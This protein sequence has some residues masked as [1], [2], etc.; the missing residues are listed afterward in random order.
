MN[1]ATIFKYNDMC[2]LNKEAYQIMKWICIGRSYRKV[3]ITVP[4]SPLVDQN[5]ENWQGF[6]Q[7]IKFSIQKELKFT[8]KKFQVEINEIK[9]Q[10]KMILDMV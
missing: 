4:D 6:V 5:D 7:T 2:A 1:K 9:E 10:N 8:N 3:I